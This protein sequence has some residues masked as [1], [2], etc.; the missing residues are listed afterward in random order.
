MDLDFFFNIIRNGNFDDF[1]KT[2]ESENDLI[3]IKDE[4]GTT[5]LILASYNN[6]IDMVEF[7][8]EKGVDVNQKDLSGNSALMGACFKGFIETVKILIKHNVTIDSQNFTGSTALIYSA[9]FKQKAIYDL[10]IKSGANPNIKDKNGNSADFI[11][12]QNGLIK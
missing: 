3:N 1:T 11:A 5:P 2:I 10:L 6:R 12:K 4:R 9:M 8:L 7:L